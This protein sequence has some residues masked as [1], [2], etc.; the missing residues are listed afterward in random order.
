MLRNK[1]FR[2]HVYPMSGEVGA[3]IDLR[4]FPGTIG[5]TFAVNTE[6]LDLFRRNHLSRCDSR[7]LRDLEFRD[8]LRVKRIDSRSGLEGDGR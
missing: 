8:E 4:N 6:Q 2:L 1:N 3:D 7:N 5:M